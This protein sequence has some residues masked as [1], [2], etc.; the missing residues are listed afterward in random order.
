MRSDHAC[1]RIPKRFL[2]RA[3]HAWR[4]PHIVESRCSGVR[5]R[6]S[7]Q[8]R[9]GED[10]YA[11]AFE[12]AER[13]LLDDVV[14]VGSTIMDIGA[15]L[16]FYTCLFAKKVGPGGRVIAFEPTPQTFETLQT[17]VALNGFNDRIERYCCALSNE[18]GMA[19]MNT[20]SESSGGVYN[21]L[22]VKTPMDGSQ[23]TAVI[24]VQTNTL[25][26]LFS[27]TEFPIGLFLKID[28]E[29]FEYQVLSGGAKLLKQ[30]SNVGMMVELY[31]PTANQ[32]GSST[33]DT[34]DLLDSF[35]FSAFYMTN[36]KT[37]TPFDPSGRKRLSDGSLP[38]DVFFFKPEAR[39]SWV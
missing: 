32:C 38:P 17:N 36:R 18:T 12:R 16:G 33:L 30:T 2:Y 29:G 37:L 14:Q 20:F 6:Y 11:N 27:D 23:P 28:V 39:P 24:Q 22:G 4:S 31:E 1:V 13:G 15:N 26:N 19:S 5:I 21:S 34:L 9:I 7:S 35:G 25:D 10:L 8:N 3:V